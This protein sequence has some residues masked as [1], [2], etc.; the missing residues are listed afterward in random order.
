M[1]RWNG[2]VLVREERES[3]SQT[4]R[5]GL[6]RPN[7]TS[8]QWISTIGDHLLPIVS[9]SPSLSLNG[10][11]P[12]P[13]WP[14]ILF[15][16]ISAVVGAGGRSIWRTRILRRHPNHHN[17]I[18][19]T[20]FTHREMMDGNWKFFKRNAAQGPPEKF[21]CT[22]PAL[23]PDWSIKSVQWWESVNRLTTPENARLFS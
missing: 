1:E 9:P 19:S 2:L 20:K 23:I 4:K 13:T 17:R 8:D 5:Q 3:V 10:N 12:T 11:K 7:L 22:S 21:I 15:F 14:G 16:I 6:F 18:N